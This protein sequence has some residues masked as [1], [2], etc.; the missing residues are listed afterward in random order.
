MMRN[1]ISFETYFNMTNK[2]G[3]KTMY[4]EL[5]VDGEYKGVYVF[6]DKITNNIDRVNITA[7][8]GFIVKF[9]KTDVEDRYE[10]KTEDQKT[11]ATSRTGRTDIS[12]YGTTVDQL[13]EIEY[14]EKDV[15]GSTWNSTV[16]QIQ[17]KFEEFETALAEGRYETVRTIIDY[18][19]WADWFIFNEYS[20]NQDA[21]RASCIFVYNGDKIEARPLWDQ[22]LSFNNQCRTSNGS[23][24]TT[25]LLINNDGLYTDCF[26]APFWFTGRNAQFGSCGGNNGESTEGTKYENYLLKDACFISMIKQRW[27]YHT[28]EGGALSKAKIS[29]LFTTFSAELEKSQEG[30]ESENNSS[31][32][33]R[34]NSYWNGKTRA[35]AE[36]GGNTGYSNTEYSVEK[37][38]LI[39]WIEGNRE[40]SLVS[41]E[42]NL[43]TEIGKLKGE[44]MAGISLTLNPANGITT[45]WM[46][47]TVTVNVE[48]GVEYNYD[49]TSITE[50][51]SDAEKARITKSGNKYKYLFPRPT[52]WGE[53]NVD[54]ALEQKVYPITV[55]LKVIDT[56]CPGINNEASAYIK[57]TDEGNDICE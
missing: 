53:G 18:E 16:T 29:N 43:A 38:N 8:D 2:W 9:D 31:A 12:T 41:R 28:A 14:P 35:T 32:V 54:T 5:I 56:Q 44:T 40:K 27:A 55:G 46:P 1:R 37:T 21:Y 42:E 36:C 23:S 6:M 45:P 4:V 25:G 47:L 17:N 11:F 19:S 13:F 22:E 50:G 52:D 48:E 34:E 30:K 33:E 10:G 24:S 15:L 51:I 57:L 49:D 20:K 3:V 7:A 26:P 39:E